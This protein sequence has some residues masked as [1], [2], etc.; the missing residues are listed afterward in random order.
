MG[1]SDHGPTTSCWQ[2]PPLSNRYIVEIE[3]DGPQVMGAAEFGVVPQQESGRIL[4]MADGIHQDFVLGNKVHASR[5]IVRRLLLKIKAA[6][7][8]LEV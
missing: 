8:S 5:G 7:R 1:D 3:N 6:Q 2:V 4:C